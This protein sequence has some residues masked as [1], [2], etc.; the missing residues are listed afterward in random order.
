[1]QKRLNDLLVKR[2]INNNKATSH[3]NSNLRNRVIVSDSEVEN[4]DAKYR[5]NGTYADGEYCIVTCS[6]GFIEYKCNRH[7]R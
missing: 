4:D 6:R 1:M 2:K 3:A 7:I 5:V